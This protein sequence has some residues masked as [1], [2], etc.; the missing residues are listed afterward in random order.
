[1][2]WIIVIFLIVKVPQSLLIVSYYLS[3]YSSPYTPA[4]QIISAPN[5][6][7][8]IES[9]YQLIV[10]QYIPKEHLVLIMYGGAVRFS[11]TSR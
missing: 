11:I 1:M 3:S 9:T 4:S 2:Y 5:V 10:D 8:V 6:S 7:D